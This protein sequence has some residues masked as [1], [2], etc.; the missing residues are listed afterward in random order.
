MK[1]NAV[2]KLAIVAN[3]ILLLAAFVSY[4]AGAF[5]GLIQSS[6]NPDAV[7]NPHI[8]KN[9]QDGSEKPERGLMRS[10][11]S[12]VISLPM[13]ETLDTQPP[14][15]PDR[16]PP[17]TMERKRTFLPGPKADAGITGSIVI[18]ETSQPPDQS[19]PTQRP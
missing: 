11:K 7:T 8:V 16:L 12:G 19:K 9:G 5:S 1:P 2:V 6:A 13:P 17:K 14:A 4:R 10:S 3:S 18:S 15:T